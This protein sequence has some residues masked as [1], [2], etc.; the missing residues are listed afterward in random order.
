[1]DNYGS[2]SRSVRNLCRSRSRLRRWTVTIALRPALVPHLASHSPRRLRTCSESSSIMSA[3]KNSR[4]SCMTG[5]SNIFPESCRCRGF[6]KR[7][8]NFEGSQLGA[9]ATFPAFSF[10]RVEVCSPPMSHPPATP[11]VI[12]WETV[13]EPDPHA[14][15]K[16]VAILF[17]RRVPLST[18]T[19]LTNTDVTLSF[20]QPHDN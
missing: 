16:A 20:R 5:L 9:V 15:L 8:E 6:S 11:I 12:T 1:M 14:L 10:L 4:T 17:G 19:D 13:P 7:R 3:R 18:G 2:A